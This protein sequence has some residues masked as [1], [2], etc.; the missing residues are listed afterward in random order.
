MSP[1]VDALIAMSR[2]QRAA[3]ASFLEKVDADCE[4]RLLNPRPQPRL[5][6]SP[7]ARA[8]VA[9]AE[10]LLELAAS[11]Q[12]GKPAPA[13]MLRVALQTMAAAAAT[14]SEKLT[15]LLPA[16]PKSSRAGY[17]RTLQEI[18]GNRPARSWRTEEWAPMLM[19]LK[20]S[21]DELAQRGGRWVATHHYKWG[22]GEVAAG[23]EVDLE[24]IKRHESVDALAGAARWK[25]D[26]ELAVEAGWDH[27]EAQQLHLLLIPRAAM[28]RAL[29]SRVPCYAAATYALCDVFTARVNAQRRMKQLP[30]TVYRLLAGES[31][32]AEADPAWERLEEPDATGFRGLCSLLAEWGVRAGRGYGGGL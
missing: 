3:T 24:W 6:E 22:T 23:D 29:A 21:N 30:P 26:I 4:R 12:A 16:A 19:E 17:L 31:S 27:E 25:R 32:L 1:D 11:E 2:A 20:I 8:A 9:A 15:A 13:A 28:S 5:N 14:I 7:L 10:K 18:I